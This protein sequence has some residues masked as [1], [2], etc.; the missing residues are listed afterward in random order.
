MFPS[1]YQRPNHF[2]RPSFRKPKPLY[3]PDSDFCKHKVLI[4]KEH[5]HSSFFEENELIELNKEYRCSDCNE[6]FRVMPSKIRTIK[7]PNIMTFK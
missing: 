3:I 1:E 7:Y 4:L 6:T 5:K 2:K